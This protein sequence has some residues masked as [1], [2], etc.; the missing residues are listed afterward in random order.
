MIVKP[1]VEPVDRFTA[2]ALQL[3]ALL[4]RHCDREADS[5]LCG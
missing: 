5:S 2:L 3:Y 1:V 4:L